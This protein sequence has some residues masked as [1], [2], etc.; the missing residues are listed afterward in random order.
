MQA[1]A[2]NTTEIPVDYS[3]PWLYAGGMADKL[4]VQFTIEYLAGSGTFVETKKP[5]DPTVTTIDELIKELERKIDARA[6]LDR[7]DPDHPVIHL[8][9]KQLGKKSKVLD[10][11]IDL[12]YSGIVGNLHSELAKAV[13]EID[14]YLSGDNTETYNDYVTEVDIDLKQ[15]PIRDVLTHCVDLDEYN[16]LIW[17]AKTYET[18]EGEWKTQIR[19]TGPKPV[20]RAAP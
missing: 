7:T 17:T 18:G 14:P 9:D 12:R 8:I 5:L 2:P 6:A 1:Q 11:K 16:W 4:D 3:D 19:F 20:G 10:R 13:P 15:T